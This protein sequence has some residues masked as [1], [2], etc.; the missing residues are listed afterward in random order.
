[1]RLNVELVTLEC[2]F[3]WLWIT[4]PTVHEHSIAIIAEVLEVSKN[5]GLDWIELL[6]AGWDYTL[7]C[8]W[9]YLILLLR[10]VEKAWSPALNQVTRWTEQMLR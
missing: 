10:S 5:P 7:W 9:I 1:M 4:Y 3:N 2:A 6:D 8:S